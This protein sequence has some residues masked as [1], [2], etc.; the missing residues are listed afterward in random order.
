MSVPKK[1]GDQ[2]ISPE[3]INHMLSIVESSDDAIISQ[4]LEGIMSSWN[5]GGEKMFGFTAL[6]AIGKHVSVLIPPE[7]LDEEVKLLSRINNNETVD[8]FETVRLRKNGEKIFVSLTISPL[9]TKRERSSA[10]QKSSEI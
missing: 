6:E 3:Y 7:Y 4:T 1:T 10:S 2:Q 9:K 8:H 5:K